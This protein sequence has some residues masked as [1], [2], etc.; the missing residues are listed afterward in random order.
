MLLKKGGAARSDTLLMTFLGLLS[1][2]K[3]ASGN[4]R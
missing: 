4:E 1:G 2:R 3:T